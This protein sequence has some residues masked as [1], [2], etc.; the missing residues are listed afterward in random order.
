[1]WDLV[2]GHHAI[3]LGL[4]ESF[5]ARVNIGGAT[6]RKSR[7]KHANGV[8]SPAL[9]FEGPQRVLNHGQS[10]RIIS[11]QLRR[12]PKGYLRPERAGNLSNLVVLGAYDHTV[13]SRR[14]FGGVD[15]VCD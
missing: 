9:I 6:K 5:D 11:G 14:S 8:A 15:S 2:D 4:F 13:D 7:L 12:S 1:M 10:R 3:G